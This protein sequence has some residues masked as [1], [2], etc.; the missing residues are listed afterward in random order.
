MIQDVPARAP[1]AT[2]RLQ[3]LQRLR[4]PA[5]LPA[6]LVYAFLLVLCALTA[7]WAMFGQ[8]APYDDE[9]FFDYSLQL[10]VHGHPLYNSVFSEYGPFYYELFGGLF[11]LI[12]H[13]STDAGRLVQLVVWLASSL[14]LG[15]AAHRLTG[16]LSLG[17]ASL[18]TSF[19][20]MGALTNE[21]MHPEALI[22]G[23]LTA[24]ALVIAFGLPVRRRASLLALGALVAALVLTKINVGGYAIVSIVFAVVLAGRSLIRYRLLR[25]AVIAVFVLVG[26]LIMASELN[27]G[28]ARVYALLAAV[29][30]LA[31]VFVAV[32]V[33]VDRSASDDSMRWLGWLIA[34]FGACLVVV[35]AIVFALGT[36]PGAAFNSIIVVPTHQSTFL[37]TPATLD[38]N[39]VWWSLAAAAI[40]WGLRQAGWTGA[41]AIDG[42]GTI[43]GGAL[44]VLAGLAILL[45][46]GN[47]FPFTI[48]PDAPF[49]LAMPLAWVAALPS[50][51]DPPHPM[52]RLIRL[53]IPS[54]AILQA[55]LAFPVAGSQLR[56]GSILLVLCGAICIADGASELSAWTG[57]RSTN[58]KVAA[59][60]P[61]RPAA[62]GVVSALV[63]ALAVGT[64]FQLV[65]Q[66]IQT[67]HDIYRANVPLTA[68]GA[69][70]L[71]LP[72]P[73]ASAIDQVV[74]TLRS[75]CRT[76]IGLPGL[77]SFDLWSGLPAPSPMTG[78]QPY[79]KSLSLS[80]QQSVLE[81]ARASPRLCV[82]RDDSD[83]AGYG[84]PPSPQL[85]LISFINN[86][87][88]P[89]LAAGPYVVETRK[90]A[91]PRQGTK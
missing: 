53:L 48:A 15:V 20:L 64:T 87:F 39:V 77:Y 84:P 35:L 3:G 9:G 59:G 65:V 31:L 38:G 81:A 75:R 58:G 5:W 55:L 42:P 32:P 26:P 60:S 18:A 61:T 67:W 16:R 30:A 43:A 17:A 46:L 6:A 29:S 8:F 4:R 12:G 68:D 88:K 2:E 71:R 80:Q 86:D 11:A 82:L 19:L 62:V 49:A 24:M 51:R 90:P 69:T 7:Y 63:L 44:R 21:P 45:S 34:G 73:T 13:V 89:V 27:T 1:V 47:E 78:G 74:S 23:L 36:T 56:L 85:P 14:G 70:Q 37:Y 41:D 25:W 57:A 83:A 66:P 76:L 79:W 91:S 40:A 52:S 22:C 10:F 33:R 72:A 50:R 28:T 54:L